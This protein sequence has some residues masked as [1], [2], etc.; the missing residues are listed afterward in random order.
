[1]ARFGRSRPSAARSNRRRRRSPDGRLLDRLDADGG[2]ARVLEGHNLEAARL[3]ALYR[4]RRAERAAP[5]TRS[6]SPLTR[7]GGLTAE[8]PR[9]HMRPLTSWSLCC[10]AAESAAAF[11][12]VDWRSLPRLIQEIGRTRR[13]SRALPTFWSELSLG[14]LESR[15]LGHS[16]QWL[17]SLGWWSSR[18]F[19]SS[20]LWLPHR[21]GWAIGRWSRVGDRHDEGV[22]GNRRFAIHGARSG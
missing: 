21:R 14:S 17:M 10:R 18:T 22:R 16:G 4:E 1:M 7:I 9:G 12:S 3:I 15:N 19:E 6:M 20:D 5:Q 8:L 13:R 2:R 11:S